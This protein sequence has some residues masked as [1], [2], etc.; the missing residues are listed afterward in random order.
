MAS[1]FTRNLRDPDTGKISGREVWYRFR[2][3]FA[4]LL[5]LGVLGVGGS[6][7]Y[8]NASAWWTEYRTASDYEGE[9]TT[10]VQVTIPNGASLSQISDILVA[11]EVVKT[12]K[13]FDQAAA[14]KGNPIIQA[15]KY[16][17][18]K[19]LPAKTALEM[20]LDKANQVHNRM[21]LV[22]GKWLSDQIATM[23]KVTGLPKKDFETLLNKV[24][25]PGALGL[26]T[27]F[28]KGKK[29]EGYVFPDTYELPDKPTAQ[30]V[31]KMTTKR[32][33]DIAKQ[34]DLEGQAKVLSA[35]EGIP[36]TPNQLVIVASII[37]REVNN[38]DDRA[39]VARVVYNRLKQG[40][41]LFMDSTLMYALKKQNGMEMTQKELKTDTPYNTRLHKGLPPG[42]ISNPGQAALNAAANPEDGNWL[43]FVVVDPPTGKT[44]FSAD[45][46][47]FEASKAKY[48]AWCDANPKVCLG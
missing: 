6:Y 19:Q 39:K 5:S 12:A 1:R 45:A 10:E 28:P 17:L 26:P 43:Y 22:E 14:D 34:V 20:L 13:A 15:G 7:I 8:T 35:E 31:V 24:G 32:F 4:V 11:N 16:K 2:G 9:G 27:W 33:S 37:E 18:K 41:P 25:D 29:A 21:T 47:G 30:A 40:I 36:L 46:A 3:A 42:P 23:A 44:E 48:K 38:P